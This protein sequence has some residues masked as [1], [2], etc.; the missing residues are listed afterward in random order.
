MNWW[1]H[2]RMKPLRN[3]CEHD[4]VGRP[5]QTPYFDP[6][7]Q[8]CDLMALDVIYLTKDPTSQLRLLKFLHCGIGAM[9][10]QTTAGELVLAYMFESQFRPLELIQHINTLVRGCCTSHSEKMQR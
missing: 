4:I 5:L 1:Y 3:L 9:G 10:A 7:C 2:E 6:A 8:Q